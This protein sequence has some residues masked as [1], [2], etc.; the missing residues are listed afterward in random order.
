LHT[1]VL[2]WEN[3]PKNKEKFPVYLHIW[4]NWRG[5]FHETEYDE[6]TR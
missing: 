6:G 2:N 3:Y 1:G 5:R 4:E